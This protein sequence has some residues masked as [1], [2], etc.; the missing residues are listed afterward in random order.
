LRSWIH[1]AKG[2][3]VRQA[4]VGLGDLREEH[5]SRFGPVGMVYRTTS[6]KASSTVP[7]KQPAQRS[8][9][10]WM[11]CFVILRADPT[12][13]PYRTRARH[14]GTAV[15]PVLFKSLRTRSVDVPVTGTSGQ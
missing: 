15:E 4:R 12:T 10:G 3:T 6:S 14:A 7:T 5:I 2:R 13:R 11:R 9:R 1:H 8:R